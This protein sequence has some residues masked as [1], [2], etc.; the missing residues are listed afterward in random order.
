MTKVRLKSTVHINKE[1]VV[2]STEKDV[3]TEGN[4]E[5]IKRKIEQAQVRLDADLYSDI[6]VLDIGLDPDS[7]SYKKRM[8]AFRRA[9]NLD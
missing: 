5:E 7:Q 9:C 8:S 3:A 6:L 4:L 1:K 2:Y